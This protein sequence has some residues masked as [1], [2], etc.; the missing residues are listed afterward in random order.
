MKTT[1]AVLFDRHGYWLG[2]GRCDRGT[3]LHYRHRSLS[4]LAN[5]F[6]TLH[7]RYQP[8]YTHRADGCCRKINHTESSTVDGRDSLFSENLPQRIS[9][10]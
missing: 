6:T 2:G 4:P 9:A 1:E 10:A 7:Y 3:M 5:S 8:L